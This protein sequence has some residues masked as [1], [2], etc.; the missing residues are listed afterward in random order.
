MYGGLGRGEET[1]FFE[2]MR[3]AWWFAIKVLEGEWERE[4]AE[5]SLRHSGG[6]GGMDM[7]RLKVAR[8]FGR[9]M[10]KLRSLLSAR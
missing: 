1:K 10:G 2:C 9:I 5:E 8:W 6:Y 7:E 4:A 3:T